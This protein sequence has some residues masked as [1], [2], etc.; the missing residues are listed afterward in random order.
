MK[1]ML[2]RAS[3]CVW[4]STAWVMPGCGDGADRLVDAATDGSAD[5]GASD[6]SIDFGG[7]G[8]TSNDLG[9]PDGFVGVA[10]SALADGYAASSGFT[11]SVDASTGVLVDMRN[12]Q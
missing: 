6:G 11:L 2:M 4:L 8:G 12:S 3:W 5:T 9:T 10:P 7:D 1:R